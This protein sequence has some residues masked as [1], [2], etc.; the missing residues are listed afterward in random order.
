M[1]THLIAAVLFI[2]L[3]SSA[4]PKKTPAPARAVPAVQAQPSGISEPTE[5]LIDSDQNDPDQSFITRAIDIGKAL[6]FLA[7]QTPNST[8]PGLRGFGDDLVKTLAAQSAVLNTVAEMRQM[9]IPPSENTT[10][11][12][13]AVRLFKLKGAA[14]D[15]TL[16]DSFLEV[17]REAVTTY[18]LGTQSKDATIQK[19]SEQTLPQI[20]EHLLVVEAMSGNAPNRTADSPPPTALPRP[21]PIPPPLT[22]SPSPPAVAESPVA[23]A[24]KPTPIGATRP[25]PGFRTNVRLPD[26]PAPAN[27]PDAAAPTSK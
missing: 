21:D 7:E 19:L 6:R 4:A 2:P 1:R 26:D 20:R 25:R 5:R 9:K 18:E 12:R 27:G 11:K 10:E 8:D 3:I 17:D 22:E 24:P 13:V 23:T 14:L 15:K 16:R